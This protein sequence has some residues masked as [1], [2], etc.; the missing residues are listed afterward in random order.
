MRASAARLRGHAARYVFISTG[1]VYPTVAGTAI[2][3]SSPLFARPA[4]E[5]DAVTPELY[6]PLKVACEEEAEAAFPGETLILRP[7]IVAGPFDP[8]NRFPW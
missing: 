2:D 5:V 8:T 3:E 6:G 7:G 4:E 1:S